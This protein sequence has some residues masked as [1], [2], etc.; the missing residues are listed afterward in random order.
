MKFRTE[1]SLKK[2]ELNITHSTGLLMLG[3]CF[4]DNVGALL[5]RDGFDVSCNP[6]GALYNPLSIATCL[7]RAINAD[8]Y[9]D[10]DLT[11]GPRG[12]HCLDYAS[13]FS[14]PIASKV[15]EDVNSGISEI[16]DKLCKPS[17]AIITF[18][19]SFVFERSDHPGCV[20]GNCHK[21][22]AN[23]FVRRMAL[24]NESVE[25]WKRIISAIQSVEKFIFTVSPIR[26]MADGF[27]G[28]TIS[29]ANLHLCIEQLVEAFPERVEYFPAYEIMMDDLRD[30]RFYDK[31]MV[32]PSDL[33]VEYI[34]EIFTETYFGRQTIEQARVF[35]KEA[36]R[37]AHRQILS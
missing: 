33:A 16:H 31:D 9:T 8:L 12:F 34:Y 32:H 7:E 25:I 21:F 29:K 35:R 37:A 17:V 15:L 4:T 1:I 10:A 11:S 6:L 36:A 24:A 28:N 14:S 20:V 23:F 26:H 30:Y 19:T 27:H 2:S 22:P 5:A 3:S 13:R 18:G